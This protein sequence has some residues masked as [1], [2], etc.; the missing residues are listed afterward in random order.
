[1]LVEAEARTVP[2]RRRLGFG[3]MVSVAL[4]V[5]DKGALAADPD[6][7]LT[8]IP[9]AG[10]SGE[11]LADVA[12]AAVVDTFE[13]LPRGLRRD[14]DAVA[15]AIRRAVRA[16]LAAQWGKKPMCHVHVLTVG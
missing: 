6:I 7:M 16:A 15:E 1:L 12:H 13:T 4:A 9:E 2:D 14:P 11:P 5:T 10:L 3:G 8:G